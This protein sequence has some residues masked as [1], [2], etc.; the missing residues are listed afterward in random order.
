[1]LTVTNAAGSDVET[2]TI[3]VSPAP[4]PPQVTGMDC[5]TGSAPPRVGDTVSCTAT[6]SGDVEQMVW[7]WV[8]PTSGAYAREQ[9]SLSDTFVEAGSHDVTVTVRGAG[10]QEDSDS[11]TF[12]VEAEPLA[13]N[14]LTCDGPGHDGEDLYR[15]NTRITCNVDATSQVDT[16]E[17]SMSTGEAQTGATFDTILPRVPAGAGER[18]W[19]QVRV[20]GPGG[21]DTDRY[22]FTV[23]ECNPPG[24]PSSC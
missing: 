18:H 7:S 13:I 11:R 14:A 24:V 22:D 12:D 6:T 9:Q 4:Q 2:K 16:Y 19:I 10:G 1:V 23:Y 21:N 3:E 20:A 5:S 15:A 17:W 8:P